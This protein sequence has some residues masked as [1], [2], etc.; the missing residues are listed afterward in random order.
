MSLSSDSRADGEPAIPAIPPPTPGPE[1][2]HAARPTPAPR[3][4]AQ[5]SRTATVLVLLLLAA[6]IPLLGPSAALNGTGED[7]APG[8][9]GIG[10]LRTVMFAALAV[11][12]G[13]VLG[14]WLTRRVPQAPED[15]PRAWSGY[16]AWAGTVAALGLASVVATGNLVPS[17]LS[18][19][20]IGG[21][22]QSRD[23]ALALIE[24]NA[25]VA[26]GLL[27][28]SRRPVV[29][30]LP[31]AAVVV[32]EALRA[33][34]VTEL[35]PMVGAGLTLVHLLCASLWAGG[36][37]YAVRVGWRWRVSAPHAGAALLALYA[38][39]AALL[40][41]GVTATG[42][43]ST[44]RRMPPDTLF[45]QLRTTSYGRVLLAKVLLMVA[46]AAL[47]LAARQRLRR[48]DRRRGRR[49]RQA[50]DALHAF[51]PARV[52]VALLGL[53]VAVSALLTALPVP[54][55]WGALWW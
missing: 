52:E 20:D 31:L 49:S 25:F 46:V 30:A 39:V 4:T 15:I 42:L 38:R 5:V 22:Y 53:V 13:E 2:T 16:A 27:A 48:R 41:A 55:R 18:D 54:I 35:R 9:A 47:A 11:Q 37:L 21:L 43:V 40:I 29:Q 44:L 7:P 51:V 17:K 50:A 3:P 32:A 6:L 34:P 12:A 24:V 26:A 8:T 10:L 45:E 23:G 28:R 1:P 19:M 36:L 33:H 14:G